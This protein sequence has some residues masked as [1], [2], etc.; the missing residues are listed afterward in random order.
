M[1]ADQEI[2]MILTETVR[3]VKAVHPHHQEEG[4]GRCLSRGLH[5]VHL[6]EE[7]LR[8]R[9]VLHVDAVAVQVTVRIA[10]SVEVG[11]GLEAVLQAERAT[12]IGDDVK[13]V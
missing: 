10:V 8:Q 1:V 7:E 3:L 4:I 12:A 9:E 11:P 6:L 5:H 13:I 2:G